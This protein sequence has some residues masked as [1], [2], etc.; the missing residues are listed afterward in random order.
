MV[1][2]TA[3]FS[4]RLV[5]RNSEVTSPC[6]IFEDTRQQQRII[7]STLSNETVRYLAT[8]Y[9]GFDRSAKCVFYSRGV[10]DVYLLSSD[11]RQ[12]AIRVSPT[13]WRTVSALNG[14]LAV[15]NH[16]GGKGFGVALPVRRAD[17]GLITDVVAPEGIRKVVCFKW[18]VGHAPSFTSEADNIAYGM[19][20]GKL[21]QASEDLPTQE[22]RP[23]LDVDYLLWH[24][25]RVVQPMLTELPRVSSDLEALA[26]RVSSR[27]MSASSKLLDWGLCHGDISTHNARIDGD[28]IT[29]FDF[30]FCGTG[31]RLFDLACYRLYARK[32]GFEND[33]WPHFIA[34]YLRARPG[35][36]DSLQYIGIFMILRH[37][38]L[39][40]LWVLSVKQLGLGFLPDRFFDDLVPFCEKVEA[41]M[42]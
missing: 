20:L 2:K 11:T 42:D 33:A 39:S 31:W 19:H 38:W 23:K 16:L 1:S 30:D 5:L 12:F 13:N 3:S 28:D 7:Y 17:G 27:L 29:L 32:Y 40:S 21:H 14:E 18:A 25:I 22:A 8:E 15:L 24:P 9:Y 35:A 4:S 34:G 26:K 41:E 37:L 10:N 36:A 6:D